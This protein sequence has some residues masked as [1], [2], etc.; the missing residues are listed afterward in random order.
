MKIDKVDSTFERYELDDGR[1]FSALDHE[2]N[3][4]MPSHLQVQLSFDD[5]Y[6]GGARDNWVEFKQWFTKG[7]GRKY[8]RFGTIAAARQFVQ[9][10]ADGVIVVAP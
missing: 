10:L 5:M 8:R 6:M 9:D 7:G 2:T 4:W 3:P 1:L